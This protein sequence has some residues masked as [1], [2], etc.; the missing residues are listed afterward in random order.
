[1]PEVE[2]ASSAFGGSNAL[3]KH[4]E[5]QCLADLDVLLAARGGGSSMAAHRFSQEASICL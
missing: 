3:A 1:M 2:A 5:G 4:T